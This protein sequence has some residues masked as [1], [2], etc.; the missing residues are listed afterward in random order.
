M[1]VEKFYYNSIDDLAANTYVVSDSNNNCV[2]IDPSVDYDGIINYIN[3][4]KLNPNGVLLT[5][6]H[7][8]HIKGVNRLLNT[9]QIPL[10]VHPE[11]DCMLKNPRINLSMYENV[12]IKKEPTFVNDKEKLKLLEDDIEV[13]YTPFHTKGSVCYYFINN[14]LLFSGDTLFNGS[15][16]RDDLPNAIPSK[17]RESLNKLTKLPKETKIYPGHGPNTVLK[18]ELDFNTFLNNQYLV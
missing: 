5:H 8:D 18:T 14:K 17:K 16:G 11:D 1:R 3:K 10:F 12:I 2:I 6:G 9:F 4:N 15:I 7:F 13:I